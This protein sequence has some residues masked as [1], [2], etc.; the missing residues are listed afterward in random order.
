MKKLIVLLLL[1][2]ATM[3]AQNTIT[4]DTLFISKTAFETYVLINISQDST[5]YHIKNESL[6]KHN[7]NKNVSY[8]NLELGEVS[9]VNTYNSLK[10]NLF[11]SD[12]NTAIILDNRLAE[13]YR[14]N[15]NELE[16]YK[17]ISHT[18]TGAD[19][20]LWVFNQNTQQLELFDYK[21]LKT[22]NKSL[23][24][25]SQ[26]EALKSNY[27]YC[28]LLTKTHLY[29]FNYFG[30]LVSKIKA[31]DFDDIALIKDNCILKKEN[32]LFYASKDS[33]TITELEQ[34]NINIKQF[35][36][37]NETLYIYDDNY[38]YNFKIKIN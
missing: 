36:V 31:D 35:F 37:T 10:I 16:D 8:S 11:Y 2:S 12:F 26:V 29:C 27:N 3:C 25:P 6:I 33:K 1:V 38:I 22:K 30:S 28:W 7:S 9:Y 32:K 13:L 4:I 5:I 15:F 18:S 20:T 17:N 14:I 34:T 19:N 21:T 23:P 24:I